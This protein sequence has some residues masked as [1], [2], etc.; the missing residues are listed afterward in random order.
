[1]ARTPASV[2][3]IIFRLA[4][5]GEDDGDTGGSTRSRPPVIDLANNRLRLNFI[6]PTRLSRYCSKFPAKAG[7]HLRH[8]YRPALDPPRRRRWGLVLASIP[9]LP[10]G[11]GST[12]NQ[13]GRPRLWDTGDRAGTQN[14]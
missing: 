13:K 14:R 2:T 12:F 4:E 11:I 10:A 6:W 3:N 9:Q 7:L 5:R 8:G 1:M